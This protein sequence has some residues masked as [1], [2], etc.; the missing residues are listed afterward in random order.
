MRRGAS[1]APRAQ[2]A[3]PRSGGETHGVRGGHFYTPTT[4]AYIVDRA[5]NA[6]K[7][8]GSNNYISS[9]QLNY[10]ASITLNDT[11][12][13][14]NVSV[15]NVTGFVDSFGQPLRPHCTFDVMCQYG[16]YCSLEV[17]HPCPLGRYG[18]AEGSPHLSA[19]SWWL[20]VCPVGSVTPTICEKGYYCPDGKLRVPCPTGSMVPAPAC[21]TE[22]AANARRATTPAGKNLTE[23]IC[24][25]EP[26]ARLRGCSPPRA[27]A[28]VR[29]GTIAPTARPMRPP[30]SAATPRCSVLEARAPRSQSGHPRA[31]PSAATRPPTS[32][33]AVRAGSLHVW[34]QVL[35]PAR[36]L[37]QRHGHVGHRAMAW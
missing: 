33:A 9:P 13:G 2:R 8:M 22:P 7:P 5:I 15:V 10:N 12:T 29:R 32:T 6:S 3:H 37:R 35:L 4:D 30:T 19:P 11:L 14:G 18:T 23:E 20:V 31:T 21:R 34:R 36:H 24:P 16:H 17:M 26:T 28:T 1:I 25:G 27:L